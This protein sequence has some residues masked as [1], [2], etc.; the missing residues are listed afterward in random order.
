MAKIVVVPFGGLGNRM[1][2][3]NSAFYVNQELHSDLWVI[4]LKKAE[5]NAH[6]ERIFKK[7][8]FNFKFVK[9]L[10]YSLSLLFLKHIYILRYPNIYRFILGL[11]FDKIYFDEDIQGIN[12]KDLINDL[13]QYKNVLIAT[14][15]EF[16]G[17]DSFDN[18]EL[19]DE[20]KNRIEAITIP[21][22]TIGIH[23]RR[24]DHTHIIN[25]SSLDT[26]HAL[27]Q[28]EISL[29]QEAVFYLATDDLNV[30]NDFKKAY[31]NKIIY[32][33]LP[34][35]RDSEEGIFGGIIDIYNLARCSKIICNTKSSFAITAKMIGKPKEIINA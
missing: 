8:G 29:N 5:L 21:Q 1:R 6:F 9:G 18:F 10:R 27:I 22:N 16:Y 7:T 28:K 31:P 23:I 15:Y 26:Y 14:C 3:L 2:V 34:L 25:E 17:F 12:H 19:S 11:Y 35:N 13:K 20:L 30:K 33:E 32:Q 4:W 24:T